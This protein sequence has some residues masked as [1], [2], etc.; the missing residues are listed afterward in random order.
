MRRQG[1]L[2]A[3]WVVLATV[4]AGAQA[5]TMQ[6]PTRILDAAT[7]TAT[8]ATFTPAHVKR[9][10]HVWGATTAGAGSVTVVIEVTNNPA[11]AVATDYIVA[12]TVTLTLSTTV[13]SDG[14]VSDAPWTRVRAR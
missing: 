1:G 10:Y 12:G 7:T 4:C 2:I 9:S 13:A 14:F 5:R 3:G 6:P 8:G 11:A